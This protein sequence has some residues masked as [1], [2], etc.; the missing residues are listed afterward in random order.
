VLQVN[1]SEAGYYRFWSVSNLDTYAYIY[2][3]SFNPA[4][5]S[6]D[7]YTYDDDGGNNR[8]FQFTLYLQ[9]NTTYFLVA[10]T[11]EPGINGDYLVAASGLSTVSL[12]PT[13]NSTLR[14]ITT[15]TTSKLFEYLYFNHT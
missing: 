4:F 6:D 12:I 13:S 8:Q 11:F 7:L 2:K 3:N 9:P 14:A 10:T 1:V 5:P 15:T